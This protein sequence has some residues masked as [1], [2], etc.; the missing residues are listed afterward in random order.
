MPLLKITSN[1]PF[2]TEGKQQRL[3]QLSEAV[4]AMLDKLEK[5]VMVTVEYNEHMMFGGTDEPAAY[6][7]L[8]SIG[9]PESTTTELSEKLCELVSETL[10]V[11]CE[12]IYIEFAD[13]ARIMWGWNRR[14]FA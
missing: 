11:P 1:R 9:L 2:P 12:R 3:A 4:S 13:I 10:D 7:E 5:Y 14:T 6:L 8:K